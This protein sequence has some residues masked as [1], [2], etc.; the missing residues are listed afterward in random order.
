M[1]CTLISRRPAADAALRRAQKEA[2]E[3]WG[4]SVSLRAKALCPVDTGALRSSIGYTQTSDKTGQVGTALDYG[5][6]VELGTTRYGRRTRAQP[7][8]RT[9]ARESAAQAR[10]TIRRAMEEQG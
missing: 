7:F 8:L 4:A 9:A 1:S 5:K 2:L 6:Y 10:E 3:R